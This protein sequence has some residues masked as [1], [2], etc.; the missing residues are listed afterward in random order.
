MIINTNDKELFYIVS[1]VFKNMTI[2]I[3]LRLL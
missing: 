1:D 2:F 3:S